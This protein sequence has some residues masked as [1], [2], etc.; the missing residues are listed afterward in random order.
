MLALLHFRP[1][2]FMI[3]Y[4]STECQEKTNMCVLQDIMHKKDEIIY[5]VITKFSLN[6]I[7]ITNCIDVYTFICYIETTS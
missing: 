1:F 6:I 3:P 5:Y 2:S 7:L 4:T